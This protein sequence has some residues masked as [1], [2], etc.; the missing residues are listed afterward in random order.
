MGGRGVSGGPG[1]PTPGLGAA[2]ARPRLHMVCC[3]GGSP[4]VAPGPSLPHFMRKNFLGIFW[5]FTRNFFNGQFLE[6]Y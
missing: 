3:P 6:F 1:G 2:Q 4:W 5:Y